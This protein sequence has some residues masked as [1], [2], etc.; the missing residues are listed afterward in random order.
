MKIVEGHLPED[1]SWRTLV[2]LSPGEELGITWSLGL[3]LAIANGGEL[4]TAVIIPSAVE[5][6]LTE[7]RNAL[8]LAEDAAAS[9]EPVFTVIIESNKYEKAVRELIREG[10]IDLLLARAD[11]PTWHSLERMPCAVAA[12]RGEA[13]GPKDDDN[14]DGEDD[15]RRFQGRIL[16]PTSGGPNSVFALNVLLPLTHLDIGVT[17][18]Y[19]APEHLGENE[20]ALG[21]ARLRRT[22][23]FIDG[24]EKIESKLITSRG[25]I[26]GIVQEASED[27]DLVIIGASRESSIDK[28]VFGDITGTVVRESKKP[29]VVF[30]QPTSRIGHLFTDLDWTL[31]RILPRLS[32]K[33]RTAAY[34]RIRR[35][36]RPN[37]DFYVLIGLAAAIAALGMLAD[38]AAVVIGAML[39]APLMSPIAGTGLAMV[40]GDGRFL[41]LSVGA[42]IRGFLIALFM[43]LLAGLIPLKDPMSEEVLSRVSPTLLDLGIALLSGMA[44]AYAL[45][46]SSTMAALPG[47][48]IAA[49]LVPP[50]A[51]AGIALAN[52]NASEGFG[53]LLL[54]LTNFIAISVA[55]AFVFLVLGFRPLPMRK[56]RKVA[57][58]R[59]A[60]AAIALLI[61]ITAILAYTTA[62]LAQESALEADIQQLATVGVEEI[63]GAELDEIEI[64]R[65]E[66]GGLQLDLVVR[67]PRS[68]P[69]NSV[70]ELQ[71]YLASKLQQ[72]LRLILT[73]ID[74]E[75]LDA[76]SPP[77]NT[78]TPTSTNTPTPRPT[79]TPT[80]SATNTPTA[81][82]T[83]TPTQ[84]PSSTPFHTPTSSPT[85]SLT[86]SPSHTPTAT[87]RIAIVSYE[88]GLNLRKEPASNSELSGFLPFGTS[89]I[90]LNGTI[91]NLEGAWQ[92]I[93]IEGV[94]GWVLGDF[95][96]RDES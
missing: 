84:L 9:D 23:D 45:S 58:A 32:L 8:S 12:V 41:R 37:I 88:Y 38:S 80:P 6:Y 51:A 91:E 81:T 40:Q 95:L 89:V 17:A 44:V 63:I 28:I 75:K 14:G 87:P 85:P 96:G 46:R 11:A 61:L 21:K 4:V 69:Y 47:V 36:A 7:A 13:Y 33:E 66:G 49:A 26:D 53:A 19:I 67:S 71:E 15:S 82:P 90:L 5:P 35:D 1:R 34:V 86:P 57:R 62:R 92:Q 16:V 30:R 2:I 72:D 76:L 50:L 10:S 64:D 60:R 73:V 31:Q 48:A 68:I 65:L 93:E 54:F 27:Y 77:T 29:V 42:V 74:T 78:P 3:S 24:Q 22:L 20:E 43:G 94:V 79:L 59:S 83:S 56:D 25:I 18:A 52:G 70:V 39:V 55:S